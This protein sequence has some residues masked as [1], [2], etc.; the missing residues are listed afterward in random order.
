MHKYGVN[1]CR[2]MK[3][4]VRGGSY[5]GQDPGPGRDFSCASNLSALRRGRQSEQQPR[6]RDDLAP[7]DAAS[8]AQGTLVL[9]EEEDFDLRTRLDPTPNLQKTGDTFIS[10]V[11]PLGCDQQNLHCGQILIK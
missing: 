5:F 10:S 4:R 1:T 7:C 6:K 8:S 11:E 9:L 2:K 3:R